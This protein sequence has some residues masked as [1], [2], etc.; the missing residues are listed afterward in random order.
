M[1][2]QEPTQEFVILKAFNVSVH[3]PKAP[4]IK[5]ILWHPPLYNWIKCNTDGAA[6]DSPGLASCG[7]IFR[8]Y[9]ANFLGGFSINIGNS[10]ALHAE[11]IGAMNAIEITQ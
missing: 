7:G 9:T 1:V 2:V 3:H 8:D 10:Y 6:L 4:V 5:E 11:L